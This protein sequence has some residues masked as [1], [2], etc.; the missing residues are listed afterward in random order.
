MKIE[1]TAK[2]MATPEGQAR[3]EEV[4]RTAAELM[5]QK[6]YGGTSIGDIAKVVG[7]TKAGLYHHI[8]SKQ[9]MLY[10]IM[11]Y[12]MD[13]VETVIIKPTRKIAD[14]E[15]RLREIIRIHAQGLLQ[16]GPAISLLMSETNHLETT[17]REE[18]EK[19]RKA[20]HAYVRKALTELE[21]AGR[22]HEQDVRITTQHIMGTIVGIARW[23]PPD[24][25]TTADEVVKETVNFIL[26]SVLKPGRS[27]KP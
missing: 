18:I 7:M 11:K 8:S 4:F 22:L 17:R 19:R 26:R 23:Y 5:V 16:R 10:Q 9:D 27:N 24:F 20:Y 1:D 13:G 15:E 25:P 6:G 14:P 12:A 21:A 2:P 3:N